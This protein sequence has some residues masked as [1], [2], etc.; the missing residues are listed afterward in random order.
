MP[1]S[2]ETRGHFQTHRPRADDA[3]QAGQRT[4]TNRRCRPIQA[5]LR[6]ISWL[7]LELNDSYMGAKQSRFD[8]SEVRSHECGEYLP[9]IEPPLD[10][11]A[12]IRPHT[13]AHIQLRRL[14]RT[15]GWLQLLPTMFRRRKIP[16]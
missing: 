15:P 5:Y 1:A 14:N 6:G 12:A 2:F 13:L 10:A 3:P 4:D 9:E 11:P 8:A 16:R 7:F